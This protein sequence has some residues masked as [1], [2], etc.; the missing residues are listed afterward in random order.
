[1]RKIITSILLVCLLV[2]LLTARETEP[3]A[4]AKPASGE[5]PLRLAFITTC[6][7]APF[8]EPVKKG[9]RDAAEKM[10]VACDW[11]GTEHVDVPAQAALVRK[12]VADGYDGIAL[13]IIDAKAF[14]AVVEEAI[15]QGVPVVA[16][17]VD[18]NGTPNA[19][20]SGVS[21]QFVPAGRALAKRVAADVPREAHLL[22]TLHDRGIS[23]LDERLLGMQEGLKDK[24]IRWTVVVTGNDTV[25]AEAL[26]ADALRKD[27]AIRGVFGTGQADTEAAGHVIE[28]HFADR[29]YW[30][31]GFDLSPEILRLVKSGRIRCTVDQQPYIQGFYPVVQLTHYLRYGIHPSNVDAGAT[32]VDQETVDRVI[33]L[34]RKKYR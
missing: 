24:N 4:T 23:A 5:K 20:L 28:K 13:S 25:K 16:F 15:K 9:M 8:F 6:K 21:Q 34:A 10:G 11:L 26:I 33:E 14:D 27:P 7:D 17:N 1:M 30:A 22:A 32:I 29:G 19:R 31:A 12:A 3:L 18:D 2:P